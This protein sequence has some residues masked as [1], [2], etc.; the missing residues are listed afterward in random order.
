MRDHRRTPPLWRAWVETLLERNTTDRMLVE[1]FLTIDAVRQVASA[2]AGLARYSLVR[3]P[4]PVLADL[5]QLDVD[6][7]VRAR[8][9]LVHLNTIVIVRAD[10]GELVRQLVLPQLLQRGKTLP[11]ELL[12]ALERLRDDSLVP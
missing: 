2:E 10:G 8:L 9:L 6:V 12:T 4:S 11:S 1:R 5:L 3:T 7:V